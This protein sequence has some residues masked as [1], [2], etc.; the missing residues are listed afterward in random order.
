MTGTR[1]RHD[2]PSPLF[3]RRGGRHDTPSPP[4][5]GDR[6]GQQQHQRKR[7]RSRSQSPPRS[8]ADDGGVSRTRHSSSDSEGEGDGDGK[9]SMRRRKKQRKDKKARKREKKKAKKKSSSRSYKHRKKGE[10]KSRCGGYDSNSSSDQG[11]EEG[12]GIARDAATADAAN[13]AAAAGGPT[14]AIARSQIESASPPAIVDEHAPTPPGSPP[15]ASA[16]NPSTE[17]PLAVNGGGGADDTEACVD[18]DAPTPPASP[19]KTAVEA[20][21]AGKNSF[22]A[23]LQASE[24]KKGTVGTIHA[25]G[26]HGGG[27]GEGGAGAGIQS[28]DWECLKCGKSNYKNASACDRCHALKRMTLWRD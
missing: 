27:G 3:E 23:Q 6:G 24:R 12:T 21:A 26:N 18:E 19:H 2:T 22:F 9:D 28:S 17:G 5:S 15:A 4:R 14:P 1:R 10:R 25:T 13:A 11:G 20:P 8:A 7:P 16:T